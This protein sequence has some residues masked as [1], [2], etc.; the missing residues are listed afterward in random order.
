MPG[1]EREPTWPRGTL[2]WAMVILGVTL[3]SVLIVSGDPLVRAA[4]V[5][6]GCLLVVMVFAIAQRLWRFLA[7]E[8]RH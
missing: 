4:M 8:D 3:L 6:F 1:V 2:H 5:A 7:G